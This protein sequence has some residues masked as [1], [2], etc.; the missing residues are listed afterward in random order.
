MK[1]DLKELWIDAQAE[2]REPDPEALA[3]K[4]KEVAAVMRQTGYTDAFPALFDDL[5]TYAARYLLGCQ[6]R[7]LLL[8]GGTG[9][10]KSEG[11]KRLAGILNIEY[12]TTG[13]VLEAFATS[14]GD[15][16]TMIKQP[17]FFHGY[18]Q[19]LIIDE[20]GA[21]PRPYVH[22]GTRHNVMADV[23]AKRYEYFQDC[24]HRARTIICTN[25]TLEELHEAYGDRVESRFWECFQMAEYDGP[26]FRKA[27]AK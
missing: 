5:V 19:D 17:E 12:V 14:T 2:P 4:Q 25:L 18:P 8:M 1:I 21:E 26:D 6:R 11:V 23:L 10:G 20:L 7:G 24:R 16:L 13:D 27:V 22:Y 3:E 15:Y 9:C